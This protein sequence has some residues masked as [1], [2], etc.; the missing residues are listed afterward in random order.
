MDIWSHAGGQ[1]EITE[2]LNCRLLNLNKEKKIV[3]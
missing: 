3:N 1:E 2:K